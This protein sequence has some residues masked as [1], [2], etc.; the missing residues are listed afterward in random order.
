L[1]RVHD[2][3]IDRLGRM[4]LLAPGN[5]IA[6]ARANLDRPALSGI[7]NRIGW[8]GLIQDEGAS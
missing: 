1:R 2:E 3:G 7:R 5:D 4:R 8:C 6:A